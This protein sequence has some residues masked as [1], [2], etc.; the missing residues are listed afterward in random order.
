[1]KVLMQ[2]LFELEGLIARNAGLKKGKL[3]WCLARNATIIEGPIK[4]L[5]QHTKPTE[6]QVEFEEAKKKLAEKH[7]KKDDKGRPISE[8]VRDPATGRIRGEQFDIADQPK[9]EK[10]LEKLKGEHKQAMKD[11]EEN[12]AEFEARLEEEEEVGLYRLPLSKMPRVYANED[13]EDGDFPIPMAD[14]TL[15]I[16]LGIVYDDDPDDDEQPEKPTK[17]RAVKDDED[18][19]KGGRKRRKAK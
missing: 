9:Y 15:L 19:K 1:M 12:Q 17:P 5:R 11:A 7:A 8:P 16:K 14:L 18:G 6:A 4:D 3:A 2:H 10:A 13:D